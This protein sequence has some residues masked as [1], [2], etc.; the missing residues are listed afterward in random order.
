MAGH[1]RKRVGLRIDMT[2][3]VDIAFLLVIFFM[4]TYN[5]REPEKV[6]VDLPHSRSPFKVPEERVLLIKITKADTI[7]LKLG[8][9]SKTKGVPTTKEDSIGAAI[10]TPVPLAQLDQ[11]LIWARSKSPSMAVVVK[12]DSA[13]YSGRMLEVMHVL[14]K[15]NNT[16]FSLVTNVE[17]N[18]GKKKEGG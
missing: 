17:P 14:Q 1:K 5:A 8:A 13:I 10:E 6:M 16:R 12:A 11:W 4:C 9:Y 3:M 18:T 2:P 15:T 7:Y